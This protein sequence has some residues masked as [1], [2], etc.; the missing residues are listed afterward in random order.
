M[1]RKFLTP[2]GLASLSSDPGSATAG[3]TYFNT[4]SNVVRYYNGTAWATVGSGGGSGSYTVSATAPS[5]PVNGDRWLDTDLGVEYTYY[6][7]G[8]SGQWVETASGWQGVQG[9]T[10]IQ[11]LTGAQGTTGLQGA[12]GTAGATYANRTVV[13]TAQTVTNTTTL[14]NVTGATFTP[15]DYVWYEVR[16]QLLLTYQGSCDLKVGFATLNSVNPGSWYAYGLV[17]GGSTTQGTGW[18]NPDALVPSTFTTTFTSASLSQT[19][20][21]TTAVN[22]TMFSFRG[23]FMTVTAAQTFALQ[24]A[25]NTASSTTSVTVEPGSWFEYRVV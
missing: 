9:T 18:A 12:T 24:V 20:A 5:S 15:T 3:D 16:A 21:G 14:T 6:S 19:A 22:Y 2:I 7:D 4:T 23:F 1:S 25:Q 8:T 17:N 13:T 10:G 11:G